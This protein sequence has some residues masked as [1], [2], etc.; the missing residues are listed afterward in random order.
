M[1]KPASRDL[2]GQQSRQRDTGTQQMRGHRML[3]KYMGSWAGDSLFGFV[4]GRV[5]V[6]DL[7]TSPLRASVF[8]AEE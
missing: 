4:L 7:G 5:L 2:E 6:C 3:G 1:R 8:L